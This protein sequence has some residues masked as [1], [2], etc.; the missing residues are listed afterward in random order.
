VASIQSWLEQIKSFFAMPLFTLGAEEVTIQTLIYLLAVTVL[1]FYLSGRLRK[2][3]VEQF[4]TR[5]RMDL[6]ARQA[7]GTIIR[8]F[9]IAIGFLIILLYRACLSLEQT[10]SRSPSLCFGSA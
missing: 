10:E 3:I 6:G 8:Y 5:T 9:V 4:L 2:W 1:L 7:T